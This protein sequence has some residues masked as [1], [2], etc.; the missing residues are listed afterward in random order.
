M[1]NVAWYS[2]CTE[3]EPGWGHRPDGYIVSCDKDHLARE[4]VRLNAHPRG[5]HGYDVYSNPKL[6]LI[7]DEFRAKVE[8]VEQAKNTTEVYV[9]AP[10]NRNFWLAEE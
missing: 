10:R 6:C 9:W 5:E 3:Y 4:V 1:S 7:T 8:R 2:E